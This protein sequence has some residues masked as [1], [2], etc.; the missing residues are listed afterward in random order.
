MSTLRERYV[1]AERLFRRALAIREKAQG[2]DDPAL[3][4]TLVDLSICV[5]VA[6]KKEAA[7]TAGPMLRRALAIFEKRNREDDVARTLR[8][9]GEL[10]LCCDDL[11]A[12]ESKFTRALAI[13]EK[14]TGRESAKVADLLRELGLIQTIRAYRWTPPD[15]VPGEPFPTRPER[16]S[17]CYGKQAEGFFKRALAI[18]EKVLKPDDTHIA[19]SLY[20]LGQLADVRERAAEGVPYL[21]R[22]LAL[23]E[24]RK[25][26][27]NKELAHVYD[28]LA[29]AP[30]E[31]K[32][33]AGADAYLAK[34]QAT[35]ETIQGVASKDVAAIVS[36]RFDVALEAGR[37]DDAEGFIRRGLE[38]QTTLLGRDDPDV[39]RARA[40][41]AGSYRDHVQRSPR[42]IALAPAEG[43]RQGR[44]A[45]AQELNARIAPRGGR[46]AP[47]SEQSRAATAD[48]RGFRVLQP[49]PRSPLRSG[50]GRIDAA[51]YS[52][53]VPLEARRR[54]GWP[55]SGGSMTSSVSG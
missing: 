35:L 7:D 26:P 43:P 11:D 27:P 40:L 28:R 47:A 17:E 55:T 50:N 42:P 39:V 14:V 12:A 49:A 6:E 54:G 13:R 22:W 51:R 44:G 15:I 5:M 34:A 19:D 37:F 32:D 18:R 1:E 16:D 8:V 29:K 4:T 53:R 2:P 36:E 23:H 30:Q 10:D 24:A 31:R 45:G 9:L 33:W 25:S 46:E 52:Q 20:D 41:L 38:I 48:R 21:L 3:A